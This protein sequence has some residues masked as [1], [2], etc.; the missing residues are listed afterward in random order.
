[1]IKEENYFLNE[2]FYLDL[3]GL[4]T[5]EKVYENKEIIQ[6]DIV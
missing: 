6:N 4:N 3:D 5:K 2:A 1:M